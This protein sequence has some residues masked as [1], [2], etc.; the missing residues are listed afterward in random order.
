MNDLKRCGANI[1]NNKLLYQK[2]VLMKR[3][4]VKLNCRFQDL[5]PKNETSLKNVYLAGDWLD[6]G[7]PATIESAVLSGF[8]TIEFLTRSSTTKSASFN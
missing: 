4:T 8:R 5:R 1:Q 3:A 2:V 6:T 7:L